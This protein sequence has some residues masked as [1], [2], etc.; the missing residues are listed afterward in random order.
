ML[1]LFLY[2]IPP[3]PLLTMSSQSPR[4]STTVHSP[5]PGEQ[6]DLEEQRKK[7]RE[8]MKYELVECDAQEWLDTYALNLD[9]PEWKGN[10]VEHVTEHLRQKKILTNKGWAPLSAAKLKKYT[11]NKAFECLG[12]I[13]TEIAIAV[14]AHTGKRPTWA[15]LPEPTTQLSTDVAG[16]RV[17]PDWRTIMCYDEDTPASP[18]PPRKS[19]R[20]AAQKRDQRPWNFG[21]QGDYNKFETNAFQHGM[22]GEVKKVKNERSREDVCVVYCSERRADTN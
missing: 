11:E 8:E 6:I 9:D 1:V 10:L 3:H 16:F 15:A 17:Y 21:A 2:S 12:S 7:L 19:A 22:I 5:R 18:E 13:A 14:H 20:I 4:K